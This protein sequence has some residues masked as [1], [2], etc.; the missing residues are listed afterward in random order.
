MFRCPRFDQGTEQSAM[1]LLRSLRCCLIY[2][3][4]AP[5]GAQ[6]ECGRV[7]IASLEVTGSCRGSNFG[8]RLKSMPRGNQRPDAVDRSRHQPVFDRGF[9][10]ADAALAEL[11]EGGP[12][13]SDRWRCKV[14]REV[15]SHFASSSSLRI[16]SKR[17]CIVSPREVLR[18]HASS[19]AA[20]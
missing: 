10:V 15:A 3:R 20:A 12:L 5:I 18:A 2:S 1:V 19:Q 8:H 6:R 7:S 11:D 14:G 4:C 17:L 13:P 16:G 9:S